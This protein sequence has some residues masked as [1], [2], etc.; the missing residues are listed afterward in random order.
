MCHTFL[1]ELDHFLKGNKIGVKLLSTFLL[2]C[3]ENSDMLICNSP[4]HI[5]RLNRSLSVFAVLFSFLNHLFKVHKTAVNIPLMLSDILRY[6]PTRCALPHCK[7]ESQPLRF[8]SS[9]LSS[10]IYVLLDSLLL[11]K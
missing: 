8:C 10:T 6:I 5:V 2:W 3:Q 11:S 4:F 1:I 9:T 7:I